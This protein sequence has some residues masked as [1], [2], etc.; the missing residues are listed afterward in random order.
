[1]P[2]LDFL[3]TDI[4]T[5]TT[6]IDYLQ[7]ELT[8]TF[9]TL[10]AVNNSLSLCNGMADI[11]WFD[12]EIDPKTN[13]LID[14]ALLVDNRYW[15]LTANE[16]YK[17]AK[18]IMK[19]FEQSTTLAGHNIIEFDLPILVELLNKH[20]LKIDKKTQQKWQQ[21]S[22]DTL[23]LS[24]LFIPH[25]PT[26]ALAK[27]YKTNI[28]YNH[29]VM[30]C[31]ESRLIFQVC[32]QAWQLLDKNK[33]IL[34]HKLLP[35][36]AKLS[37]TGHFI[38]DTEH[39]FDLDELCLVLPTGNHSALTEI[40]SNALKVCKKDTSI[41]WQ[42][43]GLACFI[44]W[45]GFFHKPQARRPLW[46]SHHPTHQAPFFQAEIA[47]WSLQQCDESWINQQ[48]QYFFGFDKLRDGQMAIVKA[49]LKNDD[50]VLG[51]LA[52]GG[53]KSLTYQLPAL[54]LSKYQRQLTVII[55]PLKALIEDQV[56]NLHTQLPDYA[57]RIAYL[58]SGQPIEIQQQIING[59][60]QG[61]IDILYLSPEKLRTDSIR[62]LLKNRPPAFWVLDEAHTLS[63]WGADFRPDFLRIAE[64]ILACYPD[65]QTIKNPFDLFSKNEQKC[66]QPPPRISLVTATASHHIKAVINKELVDK[67]SNL[68]NGKKMV[69]YGTTMENLTIWRDNIELEFLNVAHNQ[70]LSKIVEIIQTRQVQ[71]DKADGVIL[72]YLRNRKG[73]EEYAN[74]LQTLDIKAVAYHGKLPEFQKKQILADFKNN[75]LDVII[76]TNAFGMGI[77][78]S[79]IHTIIHSGVPNN[80]ES[81]VQEIGRGAR[82]IGETAK[83]YLLWDNN[84]IE[85]QFKQERQSRIANADTLK[86]CWQK[87]YPIFKKPINEH[88]FANHLLAPIL[89]I[90]DSEQLSTQIRVALLALERYGLLVEKQSEPAYIGIQLLRQPSDNQN[91][92]L[93]KLYQQLQQINNS[94]ATDK[95]HK[96]THYYLPELALSLGYSVKQLLDLLR[97]LVKQGFASW[98]IVISIRPKYSEKHSKTQM[99]NFSNT[100]TAFQNLIKH[101]EQIDDI[102]TH[103]IP[104]KNWDSWLF[105][106][107]YQITTKKHILPLLR[108][109]DIIHYRKD[110]V[111]IF[112]NLTETTKTQLNEQHLT[113]NWENLCNLANEKL[114]YLLPIISYIFEQQKNNVTGT[115]SEFYVN[116]FATM[117]QKT[118][119]E[120]LSELEQLQQLQVIELSRLD[121]DDNKLFF[122]GRNQDTHKKYHR[123]AYKYLQ[124][125]YTDRCTRIHLLNAWLNSE[126]KQ[127]FLDDYFKLPIE[128]VV[129]K[130]IDKTVDTTRPY[131]KD[132]QQEILPSYFSETQQKIIT[133]TSRASLVLAGPGSGKT[134]I[135][136]HRVAYLLMIEQIKPQKILI[137]AY[138]H[139][140]VSELRQ[141]LKQLVGAN[142]NGVTIVTFHQLARQI[143]GLSEKDAN[144]DELDKIWQKIPHL[145]KE[146]NLDKKRENARYQWLIEQAIAHLQESPQFFQYIMVDEFQDIDEYQYNLIGLLADLQ[147]DDGTQ[148]DGYE[149]QG[150]LMV[151]GDDDQNLY[152][153]RGAS[154]EFIQQFEKNYH[155][156]VNQ[157]YYLLNNYRSSNHMV[158]LANAFIKQ[159][160]PP[161]ERLKDDNHQIIAT[162]TD[163]HLP[164]HYALF[165]QN[166]DMANWLAHDIQQKI[167]ENKQLSIAILAREWWQFDII[168][169]Y[170]EKL[171][172]AGERYDEHDELMPKNSVIG[173]ALYAYLD[174]QPLLIPNA[175]EFLTHWQ[176][177]QNFNPLDKAWQR[178]L[179]ATEHLSSCQS[180]DILAILDNLTYQSSTGI[181]LIT[182]HSAK[183]LEFDDVYVIDNYQKYDNGEDNTRPLYVALTRGKNALTVLQH[184]DYHHAVLNEILQKTAIKVEISATEKPKLL[185]FHRFLQLDEIVLTPADL[186]I[187]EGRTFIKE[188]FCKCHQNWGKSA[189]VFHKFV[190]KPN[191]FYSP[192]QKLICQF[193]SKFKQSMK[194]SKLQMAGF[195][196]THFYQKDLTWY[197]KAGYKGDEVCHALIVP[198][199]K[200]EINYR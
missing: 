33:Q 195:T 11:L 20:Q 147:A 133:D 75:Q 160:L 185:V 41:H 131:L 200:F 171:G 71:Y 81:Y 177:E 151:V 2:T 73:C 77:D 172:I 82:K 12:L 166:H 124:E 117:L 14:M 63:Q 175:I 72:V 5:T 142:A 139:L 74:F 68:T 145:A 161:D 174:N 143:T 112:I 35:D 134:T 155:V 123:T 156:N 61:D 66:K 102:E 57:N 10:Q 19:L 47:F 46:I 70:R 23:M 84:D 60:W 88:W 168:Q 154:I 83:A 91:Q 191:G 62:K 51:L 182:Y 43:L 170:L 92:N 183:G 122:I 31:V 178:I 90:D 129:K 190:P 164:I 173:N 140:A 197:D 138:N 56:I 4:S 27:L 97:Q 118:S 153:F 100:L 67:L 34:Y 44:G 111:G 87:I 103:A 196:T 136:V 98:E 36:F 49:N 188:I 106:H 22:W 116:E 128:A 193:S 30:D 125:H 78:K 64:H 109:L 8:P 55:S 121:N 184:Q 6:L 37:Q 13:D 104:Y 18:E 135:V 163:H 119:N 45:L 7:N 94:L 108:G 126:Q 25:Q 165:Q 167:N 32:E 21:K 40:V 176:I 26:H 132:Y 54:I 189:D 152:A 93:L 17:N 162:K 105:S 99:N 24:C 16:F 80:L 130:Y 127:Q 39:I 3:Q 28:D 169:H 48:C 180:S 53:G 148:N 114:Q 76:C 115:T 86:N 79:G 29:P 199:V 187:D 186:V 181:Y 157:K 101:F 42:Y 159:A 1:M 107:Q 15:H 52:T 58:T 158:Q 110:E 69:Q 192:Q 120:L 144:H 38:L 85:M 198:Y 137:L 113:C 146:K 59:I 9:N 179:Q 89:D 96:P 194:Y 50:I 95:S 65:I 149:Q 150:Y 141:R